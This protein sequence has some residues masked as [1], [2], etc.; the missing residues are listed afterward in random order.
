MTR[1]IYD[2]IVC[3]MELEK[4]NGASSW[5]ECIP[6]WRTWLSRIQGWFLS[7]FSSMLAMRLAACKPY[8]CIFHFGSCSERRYTHT[9]VDVT[10]TLRHNEVRDFRVNIMIIACNDVCIEPQLCTGN[11]YTMFHPP[12]TMKPLS[13][14]GHKGSEGNNS[15]GHFWMWG[16]QG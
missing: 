6:Y 12:E 4:R 8:Q 16:I 1:R 14:L 2:R 13:T 5:F 7:S 11:H 3:T 15:D 9:Q 10:Y